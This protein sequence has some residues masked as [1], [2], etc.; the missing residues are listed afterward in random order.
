MSRM[1]CIVCF[2]KELY[3]LTNKYNVLYYT[4]WDFKYFRMIYNIWE[5]DNDDGGGA[6]GSGNGGAFV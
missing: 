6:G 2:L 4:E 5:Y 1:L 3:R